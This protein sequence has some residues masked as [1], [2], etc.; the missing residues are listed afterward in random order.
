MPG[1]E[2]AGH[3][4]EVTNANSVLTPCLLV[5]PEIIRSNLR[6]SIRI[7]G[8][9]DRLRL[10][11]KTHKTPQIV[12]M[13]LEAG[14]QKHKC[15]TL[16]EAAMLAKCGAPDVLIAYPVVGPA[17]EK[18]TALIAE[19]PATQFRCTVDNLQS[20]EQ[21]SAAMKS[22]GQKV[23]VLVDIDCGMHRTGIAPGPKRSSFT[24]NSRAAQT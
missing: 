2:L 8:T 20:L 17:L 5:Y 1:T 3:W 23:D 10:H 11:V 19:F 9:A 15:A 14:L 4:Y 7:A 12:A 16:F 24:R 6:E 13:A 21:L 18:L 22:T